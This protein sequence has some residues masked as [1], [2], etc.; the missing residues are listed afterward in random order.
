MI[1]V[2]HAVVALAGCIQADKVM[3]VVRSRL[4]ESATSTRSSSPSNERA[5]PFLPVAVHVAP[6]KVPLLADPER[7]A[8]T[9]PEPSSNPYAA[10]SPA[11]RASTEMASLSVRPPGSVTVRVT[12]YVPGVAKVN[13]G[14]TA[15][16]LSPLLVVQA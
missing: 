9:D 11:R 6:L 1:T 2:R 10:T 5:P 14:L 13:G 4:A 8:V 12:V 16:E 15:V 7:S 3:P